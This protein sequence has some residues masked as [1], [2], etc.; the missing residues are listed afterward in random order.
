MDYLHISMPHADADLV[1]GI[2]SV[3]SSRTGANGDQGIHV[4]RTLQKI[5]E[6]NPK[7]SAVYNQ[8]RQQQEKLC[9]GKDK[10]IFHNVF[11][12]MTSPFGR[13]KIHA[14]LAESVDLDFF[15]TCPYHKQRLLRS[16]PGHS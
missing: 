4:G 13:R 2:N 3:N 15:L 7:V 8:H 1:D 10:R 9:E 14:L 6:T 5:A 11:S 16:K 12:V